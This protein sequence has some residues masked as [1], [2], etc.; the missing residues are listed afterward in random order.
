MKR[1][2][3]RDSLL[4]VPA[5]S[6]AELSFVIEREMA[7]TPERLY[8]AWVRQLDTWFAAPGE[9]SM[10][11]ALSPFWFATM[12]EG[13]RHSHYGRFLVLD[14]P[15]TIEMTWVTGR[16]GTDGAETV[17]RVELVPQGAGT[18]L[19]LRH[20]GFYDEAA[21]RRHLDAWPAVLEHLDRSLS[22]DG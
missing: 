20:G 22:G 10:R 6:V 8:D 14:E 1:L 5:E 16:M 2:H 11:D 4:T 18:A 17:V 7:A 21:R 12:H 13:A 9:I 15:S 19:T 3:G